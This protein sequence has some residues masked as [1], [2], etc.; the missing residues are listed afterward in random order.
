M[1]A[2][3]SYFCTLLSNARDKFNP[4]M[5]K[6]PPYLA[7]G[8]TIAI[9]CPAGYLSLEKAHTCID[10]LQDWGYRV[11]I[12]KTLGG[13]SPNYFAG[14]DKERLADFQTMLD[15]EDVKAILCGR[16]G[17]GLSH[18]IDRI[19][20]SGFRKSPKWIIGYSDITVLH[21]H[22]HANYKVA[23][24]HSPMASAFN[25]EGY[26]HEYVQSLRHALEGGK[27][28][29]QCPTHPFNKRGEAVGELIGGNLSLLAHLTGSSSEMKTK[30][31]IL[32]LEDVGEYL[33]SIDRMF[34]QLKR[35]RKLEKLAGLM[36]GGFTE[37]RDTERP[38]GKDV[39]ELILDIVKEYDYPVCFGF[40]VS[41][42]RE[43]FALK[44][45]AGHKLRVGKNKVTL[46]E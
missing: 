11:R 4:F 40:P 24:L 37:T 27:L 8:D 21:S 43:N 25:D 23:T 45:G 46:E 14:T 9:V 28:K 13:A 31:K 42:G 32:F 26:R 10:T 44:S 15:A 33:Y 1:D 36:I 5:V 39:Y 7:A 18:I 38:F 20:F 30:G 41:H 22:I 3:P 17:Y 6:T 29:Y 19:D 16:G 35:S 34:Y 2:N 12:G